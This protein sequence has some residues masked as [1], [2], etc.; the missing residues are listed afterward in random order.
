[1]EKFFAIFARCLLGV[2]F[3]FHVSQ[4][5]ARCWYES[6]FGIFHAAGL[7]GRISTGSYSGKS[8]TLEAGIQLSSSTHSIS[9]FTSVSCDLYRLSGVYARFGYIS[10]LN[11]WL[12]GSL[13]ADYSYNKDKASLEAEGM[14]S[15][16]ISGPMLGLGKKFTYSPV[17]F[18]LELGVLRG[19]AVVFGQ[20]DASVVSD[21]YSG[22]RTEVYSK[23][24]QG[25]I[26][27]VRGFVRYDVTDRFGLALVQDYYARRQYLATYL[28]MV[29]YTK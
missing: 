17:T 19:K 2:L 22:N 6:G 5:S 7:E 27:I 3:I 1:M 4:A 10:G 14:V 28:T 26:P 23:T 11:A 18:G 25:F 29:V 24:R 16:A 12:Y 20:G 15:A 9:N 21:Y 8:D 13:K